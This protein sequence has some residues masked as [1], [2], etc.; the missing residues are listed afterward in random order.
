MMKIYLVVMLVMILRHV[1][2]WWREVCKTW[3]DEQKTNWNMETGVRWCHHYHQPVFVINIWI[4]WSRFELCDHC[5][6]HCDHHH[7]QTNHVIKE[8][9]TEVWVY[10]PA[11]NTSSPSPLSSTSASALYPGV[12]GLRRR[13]YRGGRWGVLP[14]AARQHHVHASLHPGIA[15]HG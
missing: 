1:Q 12:P 7:N 4:V 5:D 9:G 10:T 15:Y 14:D 13:W 11:S 3:S 2:A 8:G 6:D